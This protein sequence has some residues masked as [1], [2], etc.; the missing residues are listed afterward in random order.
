MLCNNI[1]I[2]HD[3]GKNVDAVHLRHFFIIIRRSCYSPIG[4]VTKIFYPSLH[5]SIQYYF[6]H[7]VDS[8]KALVEF[9]IPTIVLHVD[10]NYFDIGECTLY[11]FMLNQKL[12][13]KLQ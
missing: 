5:G 11:F 1:I 12:I 13:F 6:P 7:L 9:W 10:A 4:T 2:H 8:L 3:D